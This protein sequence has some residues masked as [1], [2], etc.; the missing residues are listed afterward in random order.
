MLKSLLAVVLVI[1]WSLV[2]VVLAPRLLLRW[3]CQACKGRGQTDERVCFGRRRAVLCPRCRGWGY[4]L[5]G[6]S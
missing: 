1:T 2:A 3:R 4:A 5:R 6:R